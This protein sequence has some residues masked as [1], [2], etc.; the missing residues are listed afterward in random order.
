V[1]GSCEAAQAPARHPTRWL[2]L[3]SVLAL[4]Q[5]QAACWLVVLGL[6]G[7]VLQEVAATVCAV[8]EVL[9]LLAAYC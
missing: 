7:V 3:L 1:G 2:L 4:L 8:L 5:L 6:T 9:L